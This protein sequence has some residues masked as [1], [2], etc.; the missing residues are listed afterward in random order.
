MPTLA[1]RRANSGDNIR[2]AAVR[3]STNMWRSGCSGGQRYCRKPPGG[4]ANAINALSS[5]PQRILRARPHHLPMSSAAPSLPQEAPLLLWRLRRSRTRGQNHRK[6]CQTPLSSSGKES[7]P[8]V[9]AT[10]SNASSRKLSGVA[11]V[12]LPSRSSTSEGFNASAGTTH[13]PSR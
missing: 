10:A 1:L 8:V 13:S 3:R 2:S 11:V 4:R 12:L 6:S 5:I 9:T 7:R